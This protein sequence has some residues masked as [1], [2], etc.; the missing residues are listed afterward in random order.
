[1][2]KAVSIIGVFDGCTSVFDIALD[3]HST[4]YATS[5]D[6]LWT[7]DKNTAKCTRIATGSSFPN[8]LSFVP[9]GTLDPAAE[10][11]VGYQG[12]S[13][14]RLDTATGV[15]TTIGDLGG[16]LISSGDIVSAKGGATYLTVRGEACA[17][18]D[19]LVEVNPATGALVKNWGTVNHGQVYGLA[20]WAGSVYAFDNGGDLFEIKFKD[21]QLQ[22][23]DLSIPSRPAGLSFY[24][25]GSTTSAPVAPP[26]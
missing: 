26:N 6:D 25:A 10:A 9:K 4:M 12:S 7:I 1:M 15:Q 22:T 20:F 18:A 2:T 17:V 24:G 16:G 21:G 3:E 11:L 14:I 5:L 19:C 8:S 13:Y 23:G